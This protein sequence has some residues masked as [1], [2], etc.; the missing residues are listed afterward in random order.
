M[1]SC[2][3]HSILSLT[4]LLYDVCISYTLDKRYY[5]K[6]YKN[7]K[8][9]TLTLAMAQYDEKKERHYCPSKFPLDI[10]SKENYQR[11]WS[12]DLPYS[13]TF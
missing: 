12:K 9:N 11:N 1:S 5:T 4:L 3:A 10:H 8:T 7:K 2:T 6:S 13:L